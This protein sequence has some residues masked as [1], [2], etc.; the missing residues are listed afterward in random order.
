M[1]PHDFKDAA[2]QLER[3]VMVVDSYTANLPW[4]LMLADDPTRPD[5]EKRPLSLRTPMVRQLTSTRFRRQVRQATL[6]RAL[7]VGNPSVDNFKLNFLGPEGK[8]I[9]DPPK[10]EGAER[11]ARAIEAVLKG[12][13]YKVTSVI[14]DDQP[15]SNVL[16]ALYKDAYRILHI[17]AHGVFDLPH[18]DGLRRS[19]VVLSDGVLIT[20]AEIEAMETVPELVFLNCCHLAKVDEVHRDGNKLAAS[21]AR[22]LI[23][24]G[25]R[26]VIVAG[27]AVNDEKASQFGETFYRELLMQRKTFG[28]AVFSAR[29]SVWEEGPN[30]NITWGAFQAYGDPVWRAEPRM[31]GASVNDDQQYASPNELLDDLAR[32]RAEFAR[33]REREREREGKQQVE[34][35]EQKL[36]KRCPPGWLM[37]PQMQSALGATWRDVGQFDK[38]RE[39]FLAAIRTEDKVGYV[40]IRD[41]EQLANVEARLGEKSKRIDLIDLALH[42]LATLNDLAAYSLDPTE[43]S[44]LVNAERSALRGSALKR[45]AALYANALLSGDLDV[46]GKADAGKSMKRALE[47]SADAYREAE[48]VPGSSSFSPYNAL[49]RLALDALG[50]LEAAA[51]GEAIALAQQSRKATAEQY[52]LTG[53][54][55]LAVMQPEALLMERLVDGALGKPGADGVAVL[56]EVALAY[57][58]TLANLTIKPSQLDSVV[59]QME[60]LSRFFDALFMADGD[61][62]KRRLADQLL[63]LRHRVHP[64]SAQ[65]D[66]PS[67]VSKDATPNKRAARAATK[68]KAKLAKKKK[69]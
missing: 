36:K 37:L 42:R 44:S 22:Q 45:K 67:D 9:A 15:A 11:E 58:Q 56:E 53:D 61:P 2:R 55:W 64:G 14:G 54:I 35:I 47:Q 46:A 10:L 21:I 48:G 26:C 65:R 23:D 51:R 63:E 1:V 66:R 25:V 69:T 39:A 4:E 57:A 7:V 34:A 19:G 28:E 60:L 8:E 16:A 49:N 18:K 29:K 17:S 52:A 62:T 43:K 13:A 68:P 24:I 32:A 33:K 31:D 38:A 40:P 12:M 6:R 3:V 41:I 20:A 50:Q 27:W 30:K 59:T 5:D